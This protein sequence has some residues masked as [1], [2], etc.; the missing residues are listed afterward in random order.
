M[1]MK[2]FKCQ[3]VLI[4]LIGRNLGLSLSCMS[5]GNISAHSSSFFSFMES[6]T[7]F[8]PSWVY[9][10]RLKRTLE[11]Q[12]Y[13]NFSLLSSPLWHSVL[14][15]I[16]AIL[17][18]STLTSCFTPQWDYCLLS[19]FPSI[20]SSRKL[21]LGRN[22]SIQRVHLNSVYSYGSQSH[23]ALYPGSENIFSCMLSSFLVFDKK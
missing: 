9:S 7:L 22:S 4:T 3:H 14:L 15:H 12:A 21:P 23:T 20:D 10:D 11:W 16:L 6:F 8:M 13:G 2:Y 1:S 5:I 19:G 18:Y 17:A